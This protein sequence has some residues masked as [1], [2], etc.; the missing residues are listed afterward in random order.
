MIMRRSRFLPYILI[1]ILY[2]LIFGGLAIYFSLVFQSIESPA[3]EARVTPPTQAQ[4]GLT[5]L[6]QAILFAAVLCIVMTILLFKVSGR[7]VTRQ[8]Q[9][10]NHILMSSKLED[11]NLVS[12]ADQEEIRQLADT[13]ESVIDDSRKRIAMLEREKK[14]LIDV[15]DHVPDGI[16]VVGNEGELLFTNLAAQRLFDLDKTIRIGESLAKATRHHQIVELWRQARAD[17]KI[18]SA[19]IELPARRITIQATCSP[20]DDYLPGS[21][22]ILL[23][24]ISRLRL[25]ETVRR[26]FISNISHELRTPLASLKALTETLMDGALEDPSVSRHFLTQID[27]EVD[28]L[29]LLVQELL[30]LSRIESG[31]VP[32]HM[33]PHSAEELI[34][35][36]VERLRLQAER[37][38]LTIRVDIEPGIP[39]V[40][41]DQVRLQQVIVNLVHNAIKFTP[42]GG[43]VAVSAKHID[44]S[45][46]FAIRDTGTGIAQHDIPRIFERF[47]KADRSRSGGGTGLG[48]AIAKHLVE[49]HSGK[50]WVESQ[51][52]E[53]STFYF[54]LPRTP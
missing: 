16:L 42:P 7:L 49:A 44:D 15:I 35:P 40:S 1:T 31:K 38:G 12:S 47:Y 8:I 19:V 17:G 46:V 14:R 3:T 2:L 48:L 36:A 6:Y 10:L 32:I 11:I 13:I 22:I 51:E 27:T 45:I 43:E 25:L 26:D 9:R 21:T 34:L 24:D 5:L 53:G 41:A 50:I 39:H 37:N 52:G 28:S 29:T 18:K 20:L 33:N 54:S 23:E 30:E 4:S